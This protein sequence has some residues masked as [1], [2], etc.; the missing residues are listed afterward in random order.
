[1][2]WTG[3]E[4]GVSDGLAGNCLPGFVPVGLGGAGVEIGQH[5]PGN[6][7]PY[8]EYRTGDG[9]QRVSGKVGGGQGSGQA[10]VLHTHLDGDRPAFGRL[11]LCLLFKKLRVACTTGK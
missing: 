5:G 1:M 6:V 3:P 8:A 9:R 7:V 2:Q 10:G 11:E 4:T